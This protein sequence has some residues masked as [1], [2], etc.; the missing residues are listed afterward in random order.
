[1]QL[2][3]YTFGERIYQWQPTLVDVLSFAGGSEV[4]MRLEG[5]GELVRVPRL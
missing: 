4:S 1:M 5:M 2:D 3:F